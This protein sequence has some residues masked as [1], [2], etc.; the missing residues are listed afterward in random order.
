[1]RSCEAGAPYEVRD[2]SGGTREMMYRILWPDRAFRLMYVFRRDRLFAANWYV[3]EPF[4]SRAP[5]PEFDWFHQAI[6]RG[7]GDAQ[8]VY[9]NIVERPG[10]AIQPEDHARLHRTG[11]LSKSSHWHIGRTDIGL[12]LN[13]GSG[14][15][16]A[17]VDRQLMMELRR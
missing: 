14:V 5:I 8:V 12:F 13:G 9:T 4:T 16:I 7:Y 11:R 3:E 1:M 6:A 17:M 2:D 10:E 15:Q